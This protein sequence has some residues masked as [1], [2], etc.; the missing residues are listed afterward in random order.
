MEILNPKD[1]RS[2]EAAYWK[3]ALGGLLTEGWPLSYTDGTVRETGAAGW[4]TAGIG[5]EGRKAH[6]ENTQ[7]P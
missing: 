1:E 5:K 7:T 6:V 3:G 2:K 4:S